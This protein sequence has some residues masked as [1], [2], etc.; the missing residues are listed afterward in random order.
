MPRLHLLG[1]GA[2]LSGPGRTTT[3][4]ALESGQSIILVDCGADPVQRMLA[5]GLDPGRVDLLVLTHEHPD[6]VGGFPLLVQKLWLAKR[7]RDLP[8][9]GPVRALEQARRLFSAFDTSGWDGLPRLVWRQAESREGAESWSDDVW[10]IETSP[11]AHGRTPTVALRVTA[12]E[13]GG[14]VAYSSDT[15]R[16][17]AIA[18]L[19]RAAAILVHEATGGF[20]GHSSA[21]DAAR[22]AAEARAERLVLVHLPPEVE[23]EDLSAARSHFP[24]LELGSDGDVHPF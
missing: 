13:N 15:E 17:G 12:R 19:G 9:L 11:G 22:V 3:M 8:V 4:L 5:N 21:E 23:D 16:S 20:R 6:H 1:T 2:S 24:N 7:G 14:V 10:S 18:R